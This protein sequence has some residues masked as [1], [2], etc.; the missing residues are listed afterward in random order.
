MCFWA[1]LLGA[2]LHGG[3]MI[4]SWQGRGSFTNKFFSNLKTV[5][6]KIL[7]KHPVS[8]HYASKVGDFMQS[9]SSFVIY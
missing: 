9:L 6:L 1:N 8:A 5:N 3:L 7:E 4:R 2:V